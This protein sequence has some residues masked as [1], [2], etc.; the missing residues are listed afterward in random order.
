MDPNAPEAKHAVRVA[1][2][3]GIRNVGRCPAADVPRIVERHAR[4][5]DPELPRYAVPEAAVFHGDR[6]VAVIRRGPDGR[7]EVTRFD[8]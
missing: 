7:A 6:I 5:F 1:T 3:G 8:G 2:P 4:L